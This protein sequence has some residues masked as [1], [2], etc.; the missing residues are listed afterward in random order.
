MLV[1]ACC[2]LLAVVRVAVGRIRVLFVVVVACSC[3]SVLRGVDACCCVLVDGVVVLC[4]WLL[5]V[6][7]DVVVCCCLMLLSVLSLCV[8]V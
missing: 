3:W 2:W 1:G 8:V 4:C 7:G 5:L 6:I